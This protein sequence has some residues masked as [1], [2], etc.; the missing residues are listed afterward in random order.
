MQFP[1]KYDHNKLQGRPHEKEFELFSNTEINFPKV[2]AEKEDEK[3][4]L[5][6]IIL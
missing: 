2:G 4:S 5:V 1:Q 3:W 6:S